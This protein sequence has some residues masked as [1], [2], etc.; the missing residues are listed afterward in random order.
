[1]KAV[2]L[3]FCCALAAFQAATALRAE[4]SGNARAPLLA[5]ITVSGAPGDGEQSL[6]RALYNE[7]G[8]A[9]VQQAPSE[10]ASVYEIEGVVKIAP[11]QRGKES[12]VINWIVFD[13]DG[14]TLGHVSQ[15]KI[16]R[17]GALDRAW[18]SIAA[19]AA[20]AAADG[21]LKLLPH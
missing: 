3:G 1:M 9:G 6:T 4:E 7:L 13:P 19:G 8:G 11:A 18:G 14:N 21:I 10:A 17:K 5:S 20:S 15:G 2:M 16:V 12:V